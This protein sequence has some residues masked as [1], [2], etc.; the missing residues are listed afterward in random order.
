MRGADIVTVGNV[1][2]YTP[3]SHKTVQYGHKRVVYLGPQAQAIVSRY[4]KSDT[5]A[6]L[7]SPADTDR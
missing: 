1:W 7:F 6:A 2:T 3:A 4:F 5:T